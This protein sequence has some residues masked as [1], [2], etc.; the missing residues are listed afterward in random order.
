MLVIARLDIR[1]QDAKIETRAC[2][3]HVKM[4]V[5]ACQVVVVVVDRLAAFRCMELAA[6]TLPLVVL[7]VET[8]MALAPIA[9]ALDLHRHHHHHRQQQ[10]HIRDAAHRSRTADLSRW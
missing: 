7:M 3:I 8:T 9:E 10:E 6:V 4:V 5:S 1:D 2:R